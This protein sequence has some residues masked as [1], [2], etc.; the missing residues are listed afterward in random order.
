MPSLPIEIIR[1]RVARA[2]EIGLDYKTYA[3]VRATT[4]HDITAFLFSTNALRLLRDHHRMA[5]ADAEKLASVQ[6]LN[7]LLAVQPPLESGRVQQHLAEQG[8][9]F[10]ATLSA[11]SPGATWRDTRRIFAEFLRD[12]RQPADQVLL[13]GDTA[14]ER[15]WV[16]A[17]RLAGY[18]PASAYFSDKKP[19]MAG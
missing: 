3:G 1:L 10:D 8:V 16:S 12:M 19:A 6:R 2:K 11:P 15:D 14:T 9:A 17:A 18:F 5:A 13:I 7:K 4:G